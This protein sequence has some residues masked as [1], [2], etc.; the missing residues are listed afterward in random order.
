MKIA[1]LFSSLQGEGK[2]QGKPCFFIRLAGCNLRCRWCD[3]PA[4][5]TGG[6]EMSIDTIT[7]RFRQTSLPYV[8]ITGGEPLFQG[9]ELEHLL[10][11]LHNR[12]VTIDIETNGTI[13][14]R[15]FQ[16]SAS[17][18]MDVKCPS[19]GE[20][21]DLSLLAAIRPEDS[22]KFVVND[23]ADCRYAQEVMAAQTISGEVF[24]SPVYGT[25]YKSVAQFILANNLRVRMQV[26]LHRIIGVK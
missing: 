26:Q 20:V 9:E 24:F 4:S 19:S 6:M 17:I 11:N 25:N 23:D 1:E 8:C 22:V 15:R 5:Q 14:F 12:E 16:Q 10:S 18:C 3:T 13:D 21:S 7:E 2:N